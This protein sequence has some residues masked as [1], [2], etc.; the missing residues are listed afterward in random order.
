MWRFLVK[1]I[2]SSSNTHGAGLFVISTPILIIILIYYILISITIY[3]EEIHSFVSTFC[4]SNYSSF[5]LNYYF[6]INYFIN[7]L[8]LIVILKFVILKIFF[9]LIVIYFMKIKKYKHT[10]TV[11]PVFSLVTNNNNNV[12]TINNINKFNNNNNI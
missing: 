12:I 7:N 5:T 4:Y 9:V 3:K 6:K 2:T 11:T 10:S 8:P 1:M